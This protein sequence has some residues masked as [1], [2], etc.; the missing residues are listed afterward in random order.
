L[1]IGHPLF[2]L[3]A[4]I[5]VDNPIMNHIRRDRAI[6]LRVRLA[7]T[8]SKYVPATSVTGAKSVAHV[9]GRSASQLNQVEN[10]E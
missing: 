10:I 5:P 1:S 4:G 6:V 9:V 8:S 2:K 7:I 3:E